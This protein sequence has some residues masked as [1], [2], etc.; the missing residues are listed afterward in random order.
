MQT[1]R[2]SS[3]AT[4]ARRAIATTTDEGESNGWKE[5]AQVVDRLFFWIIFILMTFSTVSI[6][7]YPMY[8]G[9]PTET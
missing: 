7:L 2:R 9:A 8:S 4:K 5:V 3:F 6:L 1:R